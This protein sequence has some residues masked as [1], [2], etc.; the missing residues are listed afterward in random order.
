[1]PAVVHGPDR[2]R[3]RPHGGRLRPRHRGD[4]DRRAARAAGAAGRRPPGTD[5]RFVAMVRDLLLERAAVERG[6]EVARASVGALARCWDRCPV[7]CCPNPRGDR[8]ALCGRDRMTSP[9]RARSTWRVAHARAAAELVREPGRP[10]ASPSRPPSPATST[11]SPR[12]TARRAAD[13]RAPRSRPP[14]RRV[15][16]RGGRRRARHLRA[17]AGSSTRSTAP[18]TSSTASRSTPSRSRPRSTARSSPGWSSTSPTGVE[19]AAPRDGGPAPP[20]TASRSRVRAPV[21]LAQRLI[22]TGFCYE[23]DR[24]APG[25]GPGPAAPAG[26]RHPPARLVRA[27][28]VPVAEGSLD[29]YVEEGVNLWDHAAGGLI[30]RRAGARMEITVGVG[31]RHLVV[32]GPAPG[33]TSSQCGRRGW[34]L[35]APGSDPWSGEGIAAASP[36]CSRSAVA[37]VCHVPGRWCTIC[38]RRRR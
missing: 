15:P 18:S 4:G 2:V 6:E 28:P 23:A 3:V 5:P 14:R 24:A 13:P 32:C 30:A 25:R 9:E 31:G 20:A 17:C 29:G 12:P 19:Y 10:A 8:P 26:A 37:R 36:N 1:M 22:A 7:G 33:S 35:A 34:Y 11:S 38:R 27:R 16:R 21:P